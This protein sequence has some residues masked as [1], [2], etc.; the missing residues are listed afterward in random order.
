MVTRAIQAATVTV[1]AV[2]AIVVGVSGGDWTKDVWPA[3]IWLSLTLGAV[4]AALVFGI[5]K[6]AYNLERG[7][8]ARIS[9]SDPR[10]DY[11]PWDGAQRGERVTHHYY[12]TISNIS[13]GNINNC[14][15]REDSFVNNRDHEAPAKGRFLRLRSE[16]TADPI[17]HEYT[18]TFDL[19]GKDDSVEIDI[20]SMNEGEDNSRVVMYYATRPT[21]HHPNAIIRDLFPHFLTI[22]IT[23]DNLAIPEIRK[24]KICITG[25]GDLSVESL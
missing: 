16:R 17:T 6:R 11:V 4:V 7:H 22:Y 13:F 5:G 1:P 21:Q 10:E 2:M 3:W 8:Q 18:R 19:R 12:I 9:I 15:V 14:S 24:F 25:R 20:C 23:A